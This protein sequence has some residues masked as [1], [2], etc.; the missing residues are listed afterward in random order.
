MIDSHQRTRASSIIDLMGGGGGANSG[1][2]LFFDSLI[3]L[4]AV[5][6][7]YGEEGL[8]TEQEGI[9][10]APMFGPGIVGECHLTDLVIKV[11]RTDR[12][13]C[14]SLYEQPK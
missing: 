13:Y 10:S 3:S 6:Q 4:L 5:P 12:L 14:A 1:I 11:D 2:Y 9:S 7:G 8:Y